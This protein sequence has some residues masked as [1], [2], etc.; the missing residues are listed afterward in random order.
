MCR[1]GSDWHVEIWKNVKDWKTDFAETFA[2]RLRQC[3]R[4]M[5][6]IWQLQEDAGRTRS[7]FFANRQAWLRLAAAIHP[8]LRCA[9][10]LRLLCLSGL[11]EGH[12]VVADRDEPI[13]EFV[14]G[15]GHK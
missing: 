4:A 5:A 14:G 7:T 6:L 11:K 9:I 3:L 10:W 8:S 2:T 12:R 1:A 13:A 15:Y